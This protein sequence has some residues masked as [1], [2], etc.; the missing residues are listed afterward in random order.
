MPE[1]N[2]C[3]PEKRDDGAILQTTLENQI[4]AFA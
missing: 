3:K 4:V 1:K 2:R